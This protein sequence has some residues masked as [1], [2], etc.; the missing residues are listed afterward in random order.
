MNLMTEDK[1]GF[2]KNPMYKIWKGMENCV[3]KNLAKSIGVS[4]FNFQMIADMLTYAEIKPSYNQIELNP[5]NTQPE[6][7]KF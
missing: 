5:F 4:N 2:V 1:K 3:K 6:L 7:V